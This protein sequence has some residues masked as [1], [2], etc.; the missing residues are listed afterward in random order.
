MGSFFSSA[1]PYT[2]ILEIHTHVLEIHTHV[3]PKVLQNS[4]VL[5]KHIAQ[6]GEI[7]GYEIIP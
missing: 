5:G 4:F 2:G 1:S 3:L 7:R 6:L